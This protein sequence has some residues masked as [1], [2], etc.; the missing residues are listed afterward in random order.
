M[1]QKLQLHFSFEYQDQIPRKVILK[2]PNEHETEVKFKKA[3]QSLCHLSNF[4]RYCRGLLGSILIYSFMDNGRF[5]VSCF[6]NDC[7]EVIY[8]ANRNFLHVP[9]FRQGN[10]GIIPNYCLQ[11]NQTSNILFKLLLL[12]IDLVNELRWKFLVNM[13]NSALQ[14]GKQ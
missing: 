10:L 1:F 6:K 3:E 5:D 13:K 14:M 7:S 9:E 8:C 12:I 4:N 2:F 11:Y